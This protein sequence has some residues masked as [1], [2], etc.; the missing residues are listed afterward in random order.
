[1][2][3]I[4]GPKF[5]NLCYTKEKYAPNSGRKVPMAWRFSS[6]VTVPKA[7]RVKS[8]KMPL[9]LQKQDFICARRSEMG[10][11][12]CHRQALTK[13]LLIDYGGKKIVNKKMTG[14]SFLEPEK[15]PNDWPSILVA[16][17]SIISTCVIILLGSTADSRW[18]FF[19]V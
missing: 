5:A 10:F 17:K 8:G 13:C 11:K 19:L 14:P 6:D 7:Y 16:R 3:V 1:M 9:T 18:M 15:G 4:F 12:N 2:L